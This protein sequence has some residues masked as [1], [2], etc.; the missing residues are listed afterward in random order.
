[1]PEINEIRNYAD[2]IKKYAK[3]KELRTINIL[4]GRYKTHGTF[5]GYNKLNTLLPL[6]LLDV[7]TKGKLLYIIFDKNIY[8][9]NTM[10]LA[11]GWVGQKPNSDKILFSKNIQNYSSYMP[12]DEITQFMKNALNHLNIGFEFDNITLYFHDSLSFGTVKII[13][14]ID[15]LEKKLKTI[16]PDVMDD[17]TTLTVFKERILLPKNLPKAIGIVLMEQNIISGIGNYLRADILYMSKINPFRKV[18][19]LSNEELET[20]YLNCKILTWGEYSYSQAKKLGYIN[21]KTKLPSDY[22]RTFFIYGQ[23]SD[24]F[25]N[26]VKKDE[27]FV[28]SQ[29]RFI[30][31]VPKV[32]I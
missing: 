12:K 7:K 26:K 32:Q 10:G 27:L 17:S 5:D 24:M 31:W 8:M 1:M 18:K 30:Y 4:S 28:G 15:N 19:N 29:K 20:I 23:E 21:S 9:L 14:G 2:F 22:N 25:D 11:G 3:G 13:E 16:G 6:K